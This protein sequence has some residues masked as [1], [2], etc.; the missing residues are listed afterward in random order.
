MIKIFV[1]GTFDV[2]HPGHMALLKTAKKLGTYLMVSIDSDERVR[3]KKGIDRPFN[4]EITRQCILENIKWVDKVTIFNTDDEL[5]SL[6]K[7][8][9]PD[10]MVIGSDWKGK[11]I[12][13]FEYAKQF[14]FFDRDPR[15]STT[16]ILEDFIN[17]R[18]LC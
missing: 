6:I 9:S 5:K 17:R 4:D 18:Q 12:I 15:Y 16:K 13:G 10:I 8:Y 3:E 14:V 11:K 2:L 7:D 1:N